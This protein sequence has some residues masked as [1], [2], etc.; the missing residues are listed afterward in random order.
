MMKKLYGFI[1]LRDES[2]FVLG[3][4]MVQLGVCK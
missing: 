2:P 3:I 1:G 4:V